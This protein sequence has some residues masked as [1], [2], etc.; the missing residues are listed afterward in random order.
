[1]ELSH[2]LLMQKILPI[3]L[4]AWR[5]FLKTGLNGYPADIKGVF[6]Q[7]KSPLG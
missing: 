1:M 2:Y 3:P 7:G 5:I 4:L 6:I